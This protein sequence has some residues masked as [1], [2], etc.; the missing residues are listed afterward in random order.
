MDPSQ[1]E[2]T[3][4]LHVNAKRVMKAVENAVSSLEDAFS[5]T[6]YLEELG[7][8]HK[9]ISIR[10]IGHRALNPVYFEVRST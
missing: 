2:S 3:R 6:G 7:R 9:S 5:V 1:L 8:R 10:G 4:A